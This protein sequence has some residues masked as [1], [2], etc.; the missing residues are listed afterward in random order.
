[1][2]FGEYV[3]GGYVNH[4]AELLD[5]GTQE[6]C[7]DGVGGHAQWVLQKAKDTDDGHLLELLTDAAIYWEYAISRSNIIN[8]MS[9]TAQVVEVIP[10]WQSAISYVVIGSGI[11]TA[12]CCLMLILSKIRKEH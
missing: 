11:L 5:A 8:G 10:W 6:W 4:A 12:L 1:P 2:C 9:S 3:D 7:L